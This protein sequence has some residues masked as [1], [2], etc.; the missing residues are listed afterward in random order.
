MAI[1][2]YQDYL[3]SKEWASLRDRAYERADGT[4][5]LCG[6]KPKAVHHIKY[7]KHNDTDKLR[8]L[9]AVCGDCHDKLHGVKRLY[10]W[11]NMHL[12]T[13]KDLSNE[14]EDLVVINK[15]YIQ[16]ADALK[17]QGLENTPEYIELKIKSQTLVPVMKRL[18]AM[19]IKNVPEGWFDDRV[20]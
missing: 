4:C 12:T 14:I 5:E 17:E 11:R 6:G 20:G 19:H 10:N 9:L 8:N 16:E 1:K 15:N 13:L 3:Q 18:V 7:P 2:N